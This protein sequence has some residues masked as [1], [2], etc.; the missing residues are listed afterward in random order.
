L[1]I[2]AVKE[3]GGTERST[4]LRQKTEKTRGGKKKTVATG[5]TSIKEVGD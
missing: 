5:H 4:L 2:D 1:L 3:V